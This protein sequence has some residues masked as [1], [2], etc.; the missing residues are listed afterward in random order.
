MCKLIFLFLG[1]QVLKTVL[2]SWKAI[3]VSVLDVP[4][5]TGVCKEL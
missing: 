3:I 2:L 5:V 4:R 1:L